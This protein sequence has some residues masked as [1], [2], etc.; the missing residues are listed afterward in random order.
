MNYLGYKNTLQGQTLPLAY[1]NLD[2]LEKN[3]RAILDRAGDM[4]VRVVSKSLRSVDIIK[5]L[6]SFSPRFQGVMC[7]HPDEAAF[8]AEQG[9]DDL[10]V[11]YPSMQASAIESAC[12][13][14]L[15]GKTIVLMVDSPEHVELIARIAK[16]LGVVQPVCMDVD[17]STSFPGIYFGVRRSPIT[18]PDKAVKLYRT[19][20]KN[21][22]VK[23]DGVMG[24]EAQIAG[25]GE[26]TPGKE[27]QN[28][29]VPWLKRISI[30]ILTRRR[31]SVVRALEQ[32]GAC[33]R[34][35]NGG[36]TGSIDSTQLDP[37]VTEL[38]VGSGFYSPHLF[39]YYNDFNYLPAAGFAL[40]V[41]RNSG[42]GYVTCSG[43]G[44][45]ASGGV[46]IEKAPKP[47]LPEGFV[48]DEN[49]GA[50]EVQTPLKRAP[51]KQSQNITSAL[52]HG[53]PVL[54]RH[55]KAGELC[56]RFNELLLIKNGEVVDKCLTYRGHGKSFI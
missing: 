26:K 32:A 56:E 9:L 53:D 20:T 52:A 39:D 2:Y 5:R 48:L 13:A 33:L 18:T 27:L 16:Q 40:E 1:V 6:L 43:G 50:G 19:I 23:L 44:Y 34:F 51:K 45:I 29:A 10:L 8:L 37:S 15:S 31:V 38:A 47:Y 42:D 49:E 22:S 36:G 17:M 55:S 24:Y 54:F 41:S 4:P 28:K 11:A 21:A 3:A 46:G 14:T 25:V 30:P 35:V 12:K 7:F